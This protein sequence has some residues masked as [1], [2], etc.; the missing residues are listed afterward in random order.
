MIDLTLLYLR[1][2]RALDAKPL[3]RAQ[4][5][6]LFAR[7]R[8]G[9]EAARQEAIEGNLR[10]VVTV[11]KKFQ[12]RGMELPELIAV[13]NDGLLEAVE[14]FEPQKGYKFISYAVWWIRQRLHDA[15]R[16][17]TVRRPMNAISDHGKIAP[18]ALRLAQQLGREPSI[19]EL[20]DA[21]GLSVERIER[22]RAGA[23]TDCSID[24]EI[25]LDGGSPLTILDT[26]GSEDPE[27]GDDACERLMVA[28]SNLDDREQEI[29]TRYYGLGPDES[30]TLDEIG[31]RFH[32]TRERIRQIRDRALRK[33]REAEVVA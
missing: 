25:G 12:G 8:A 24:A 33:L 7:V 27:I 16:G 11:A 22:C 17:R 21:T 1:D 30:E 19:Y 6:V 26:L 20:S 13:G 9:D 18:H 28:L 5:A 31:Q 14:R 10:F 4:E 23:V 32:L 15:L 29:L 2:M 3:S